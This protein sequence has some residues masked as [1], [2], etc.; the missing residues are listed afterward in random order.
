MDRNKK[1]TLGRI[2]YQA[3][4][5]RLNKLLFVKEQQ[6]RELQRE[7][8]TYELREIELLAALR[9]A[10]EESMYS[11]T[12]AVVATVTPSLP[13]TNKEEF[14]NP[15]LVMGLGGMGTE[16]LNRVQ[17]QE[18]LETEWE[19]LMAAFTDDIFIQSGE[20]D[21]FFIRDDEHK[22]YTTISGRTRLPFPIIEEDL[23]KLGILDIRP[24]TE[25]ETE[26]FIE[27]N[28]L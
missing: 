5:D 24:A 13:A 18:G 4:I 12:Q 20:P 8:N 6:I 25:Q 21:T 11:P 7:I 28:N 27:Q 23:E 14:L 10:D 26:D 1:E 16:E 17:A 19:E 3:E 9:K 2:N 15:S 22:C